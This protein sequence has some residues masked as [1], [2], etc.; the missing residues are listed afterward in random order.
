MLRVALKKTKQGVNVRKFLF[1]GSVI[2]AVF[3]GWHTIQATRHGPNDWRTILLWVSWGATMAIA[4]G[5]VI[6]EA[7]GMNELED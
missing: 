4:V 5:T 6:M 3:G 7:R 1:N 2:S